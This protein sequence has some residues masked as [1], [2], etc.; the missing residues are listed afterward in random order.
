M[1]ILF[2]LFFRPLLSSDPYLIY[3]HPFLQAS[4][5]LFSS[6]YISFVSSHWLSFPRSNFFLVFFLHLWLKKNLCLF[7][8]LYFFSS[9]FLSLSFSINFFSLPLPISVL[10][11]G[12]LI[13]KAL[14]RCELS[15]RLIGRTHLGCSASSGGMHQRITL[16][17]H[18]ISA[19]SEI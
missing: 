18:T 1:Q 6:V 16:H 5:S 17:S 3:S 4:L 11:S 9:F 12:F 13:K 19:S 8:P 15:F 2:E 7:L 14:P 10:F